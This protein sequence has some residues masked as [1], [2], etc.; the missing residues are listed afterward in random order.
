METKAD[1]RK[2]YVY[3]AHASADK[4]RLA[5]PLA[6]ALRAQ[7]IEVWLDKWEIRSGD[8]LRRK[9][10]E[11]LGACTHFVVLL[12]E[13][14]IGRPWVETEIDVGFTNAVEGKAK[15]IGLRVGVEV[16]KLSSFLQTRLCPPLDVFDQRQVD[17][18]VADILGISRKPPLGSLPSYVK[19]TP[20]GLARWSPSACAVAEYLVKN[21]Q[22]GTKFDPQMNTK[23]LAEA[24]GMP[25][26]DVRLGKLDLLDAGVI[27]ESGEVGLDPFFWPQE[28]LFVEF[29]RFFMDFDNEKDAVELANRLLSE[30]IEVL[31]TEDLAARFP[32][33]TVRRMNSAL[34]YLDAAGAIGTLDVCGGPYITPEVRVTDRTRKFARNRQ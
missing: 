4:G 20:P 17:E 9:M 10:E 23:G 26:E 11:G 6:T 16:N 19:S 2:P 14:S 3:L 27:E 25:I 18:L 22:H 21:S 29:D 8:S 12:T 32:S 30:K 34:V 1:D 5:E 24:L 13:N 28:A 33:W 15:F 31:D 7:G